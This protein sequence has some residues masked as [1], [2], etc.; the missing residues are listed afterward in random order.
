MW[1]INSKSL[2]KM[3]VNDSLLFT[4]KKNGKPLKGQGDVS[5]YVT[6]VTQREG[7]KFKMRMMLL[8]DPRTLAT[9]RANMITR[10]G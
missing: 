2:E 1:V 5:A 8:I 7:F 3:K 10:V 6:R 4:S 9:T